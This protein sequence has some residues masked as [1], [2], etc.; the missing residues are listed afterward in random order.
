[1]EQNGLKRAALYCRLSQDDGQACESSSIQTQKL[2]LEQYA[3]E[4]GFFI[5]DCYVDDGYSGLNYDRPSFQ[6]LLNDIDAG[7]IDIVITKDLSRLGRDYI[8]TG[9]Y[10][11][12]YFANK[13]IRYIAVNDGIDTA[14]SDNDIAPFKNI[15]NDMYAKDLSRKVKTAKRQRM[16]KGYYISSQPPYGY[17][18]NPENKK[19]LIIDEEAAQ[20][21]REIFGLA[22]KGYGVVNIAKELTAKKILIPSAYKAMRGDTRFKTTT[23][24]KRYKDE[25]TWCNPTLLKILR[26]RVYVGDMEG[27][28][29]EVKNYKTKKRIRVPSEQHII[30]ENTHEPIIAREDF[31][32]V[33]SLISARHKASKYNYPNIFKS[34]LFCSECGYRLTI[35]KKGERYVYRCMHR[36]KEPDKCKRYNYIYY[37]DL[38]EI[39]EERIR[40]LT[41][42][43]RDD[44]N[45]IEKIQN[46][47]VSKDVQVRTEKEVIKIEKRLKALD[48]ILRKLY[49]DYASEELN[50]EN[51]QRMLNEYQREQETL[52]MRKNEIATRLTKESDI[53]ANFKKLKE[54]TEQFLDF[55]QI[56]ANM[57][58]QLIERIEICPP[59]KI[60]GEIRQGINIIY[61]FIGDSISVT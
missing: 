42:K 54:A 45:L 17:K 6:R 25:Y 24:W 39:V 4:K 28:K 5:Q 43:L 22:L 41:K 51:Y 44:N 16:K 53:I 14:K 31:D 47:V 46:K 34:V 27:H 11:E 61:R 49:E 13:N 8:Q 32:Q 50:V 52:L 59:Q 9:Y 21:V 1:M 15:L 2:I 30:V 23:R 37:D 33:Q 57:L 29:Y 7:K 12:I 58:N 38:Y 26:D 19:E 36:F 48:K 20:T 40:K 35:A 18:P 10:T 56:S 3:K 55:E 60:N